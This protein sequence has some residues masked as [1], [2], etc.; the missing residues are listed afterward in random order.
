MMSFRRKCNLIIKVWVNVKMK[1]NGCVC[2][3]KSSSI[4][5]FTKNQIL[6]SLISKD[7]MLNP[8][9]L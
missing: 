9:A 5:I 8:L 4:K 3:G 2:Y 1:R 6:I 7:L